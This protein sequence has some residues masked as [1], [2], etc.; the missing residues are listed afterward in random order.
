MSTTHMDKVSK[1]SNTS[2]I[3][4]AVNIGTGLAGTV[5]S[6]VA[7]SKDTPNPKADK[8]ANIFAGTS[9]I[10]SGTSTVFNAITLKAINDNLK[11]ATAC[12]EAIYKL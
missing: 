1:N 4:S 3:V 10:A 2:K 6:A 7:N 12:E 11:S 9:A 5:T 8:A